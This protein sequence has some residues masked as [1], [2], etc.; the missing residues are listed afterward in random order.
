[1]KFDSVWGTWNTTSEPGDCF[2]Y[3]GIPHIYSAH[4]YVGGSSPGGLG[5]D[6]GSAGELLE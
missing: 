2:N 4:W 6:G 5:G 1:M 3:W